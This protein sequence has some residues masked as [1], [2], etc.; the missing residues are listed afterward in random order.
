M[1]KEK[2]KKVVGLIKYELS[3]KIMTK[4]FGLR[5]KPYNFLIDHGSEVKKAKAK[6]IVS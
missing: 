6:K 5:A 3:E 4:F 1:P 2:Y